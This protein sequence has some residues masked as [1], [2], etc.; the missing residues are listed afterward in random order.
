MTLKEIGTRVSRG[1]KISDDT[2]LDALVAFYEEL[3]DFNTITLHNDAE[4][5]DYITEDMA[6]LG[7]FIPTVGIA[8]SIAETILDNKL[9]KSDYNWRKTEVADYKLSSKSSTIHSTN[10]KG[11]DCNKPFTMIS[12]MLTNAYYDLNTKFKALQSVSANLKFGIE[13]ELWSPVIKGKY[14]K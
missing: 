5:L 9:S 6:N 11:L 14:A 13:N 12:R 10:L 1:E 3:V 2:V 7:Q 8:K 4:A